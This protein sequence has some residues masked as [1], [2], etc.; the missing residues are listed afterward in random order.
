M[1]FW[2]MIACGSALETLGDIYYKK[3]TYVLGTAFYLTGSIFWALSLRY[4][5]LAIAITIFA[6]V[7]LLSGVACGLIFFHEQLQPLQWVGVGLACLAVC[8]LSSGH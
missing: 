8:L 1:M 7:C 3:E 6:L 4:E 2:L 5:G